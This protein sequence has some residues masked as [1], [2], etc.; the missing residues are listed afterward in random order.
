[1]TADQ[2]KALVELAG[3][4]NACASFKNTLGPPTVFSA[5][6]FPSLLTLSETVGAKQLLLN[7]DSTVRKMRLDAAAWDIDTP[8]DL[9]HLRDSSAY[10]FGN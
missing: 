9:E 7:P 4:D 6:L 10:I 2:L 1:M 3:T 5:A 8:E